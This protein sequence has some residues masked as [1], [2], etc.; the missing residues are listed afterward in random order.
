MLKSYDMYNPQGGKKQGGMPKQGAAMPKPPSGQQSGGGHVNQVMPK[1][2]LGPR[3]PA[4]GDWHAGGGGQQPGG[5]GPKTVAGPNGTRLVV[6]DPNRFQSQIDEMKRNGTWDHTQNHKGRERLTRQRDNAKAAPPGY[7]IT[8]DGR[9]EPNYEKRLSGGPSPGGQQP[10]PPQSAQP[11]MGMPGGY[12]GP[13][14]PAPNQYVS[15]GLQMAPQMGM[16]GGYM[17]PQQPMPPQ[18]AQPQM[19]PFGPM[20]PMNFGNQPF[21]PQYGGNMQQ[22]AL[23]GLL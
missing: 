23:G 15:P 22:M 8:P 14:Q 19:G 11:Q 13:Q 20:G 7:F 4:G 5:G 10:M 16:P 12:M 18:F 3:Q 1:S 6:Q 9:T 17:G 2:H 21:A